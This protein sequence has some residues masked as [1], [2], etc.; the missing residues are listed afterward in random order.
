MVICA[1][2]SW[3]DG[4]L[5]RLPI[6]TVTL[7]HSK[8]IKNDETY[9]LNFTDCSSYTYYCTVIFSDTFVACNKKSGNRRFIASQNIS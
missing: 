1:D 9:L 3:F 8:S 6:G 4:N 2:S 5:M 7:K